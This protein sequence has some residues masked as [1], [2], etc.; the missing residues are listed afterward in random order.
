MF[1]GFVFGWGEKLSK[2]K[3]GNF[4]VSRENEGFLLS[5]GNSLNFCC[6]WEI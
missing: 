3:K 6:F 5:L 2:G 1:V 4:F